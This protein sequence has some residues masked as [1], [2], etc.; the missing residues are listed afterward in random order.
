M[1]DDAS[2]FVGAPP[3]PPRKAR[4]L[5]RAS[6][7]PVTAEPEPDTTPAADST[8]VN[9]GSDVRLEQVAA[10]AAPAPQPETEALTAPVVLQRATELQQ[11]ATVQQPSGEEFEVPGARRHRIKVTFELDSDL[12]M[13]ARTMFKLTGDDEGD[14]SFG[15]ML[16]TLI[17]NEC[18]RRERLYNG[19][20]PFEGTDRRLR[21]G[22][23]LG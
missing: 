1:S 10:V 9:L 11:P 16:A 3:P 4:G 14:V 20:R 2:R 13:R 6:R 8:P 15:G 7:P 22:R 12:R 21:P 17:E 5:T 23:P 19:G 18:I